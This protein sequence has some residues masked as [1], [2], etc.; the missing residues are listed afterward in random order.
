MLHHAL[1]ALDA[2]AEWKSA[3][4]MPRFKALATAMN[5]KLRDMLFPLFVAIAGRPV[6]LPLFD[7]MAFLGPD[8]TRARLRA[9][10]DALGGVSKQEGKRLAAAFDALPL[11]PPA[12]MS[13]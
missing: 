1:S 10:L 11:D 9:A 13:D 2:Q 12:A 3:A 4:L 5:L 8:L 6:A 7:S